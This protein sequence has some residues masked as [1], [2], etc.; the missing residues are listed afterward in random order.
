MEKWLSGIVEAILC[1]YIVNV[2]D[3]LTNVTKVRELSSCKKCKIEKSITFS[4]P[5]TIIEN[6]DMALH[7]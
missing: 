4:S 2:T 7:Y 1:Q 5:N 3:V 6:E